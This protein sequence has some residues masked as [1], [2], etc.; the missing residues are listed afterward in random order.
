MKDDLE[1]LILLKGTVDILA[2]LL[3][4]NVYRKDID[5]FWEKEL[6]MCKTALDNRLS[7]LLSNGIIDKETVR[8]QGNPSKYFLT[9]KGK[10]C[11]GKLK[12]YERKVGELNQIK[13]EIYD[14]MK[15]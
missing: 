9:E 15:S 6:K 10:T 3:D 13:K 1:G 4:G 5:V 2:F 14:I 12:A 7:R 8:K 11:R